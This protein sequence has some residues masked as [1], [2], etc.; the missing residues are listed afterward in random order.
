MLLITGGHG[1]LGRALSMRLPNALALGKG[2]LDITD[3]QAVADFIIENNIDTIINCAAYTAVD[4]AEDNFEL[5]TTINRDGALNLAKTGVTIVHIST[6]YIFDGT[7]N[8]PYTEKDNPNP[9][10]VYGRS[11]L[12]GEHA[13]LEHASTTI[14]VRTSWLYDELGKNF[15][16]TIKRIAHENDSITVVS[17]QVG[18]PTYVGDLAQVIVDILPKIKEGT[19]EIY[20]YANEGVCSWYDFA[21]ELIKQSN[22]VC[23]V[24]AIPSSDYPTKAARPH[25]SVL[26]KEKI[27]YD[28]N[29]KIPHWTESLKKCLNQF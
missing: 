20:N 16:T 26:S 17:D 2:D 9:Q 27:K 21:H 23:D 13:V 11:K 14:I 12:A 8:I 1:Q 5:A 19:K 10:S 24:I 22:L 7:A 28:F 3:Q 25:Y 6:D 29:I 15:L 4:N 18:T